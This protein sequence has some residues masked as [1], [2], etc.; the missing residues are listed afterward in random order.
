LQCGSTGTLAG[1]VED[2]LQALTGAL[3]WASGIWMNQMKHLEKKHP[4]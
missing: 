4:P 3:A 2:V 1:G